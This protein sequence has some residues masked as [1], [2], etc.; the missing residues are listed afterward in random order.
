MV[1]KFPAKTKIGLG[2]DKKN[3]ITVWGLLSETKTKKKT[4]TK[5]KTKAKIETET[6]TKTETETKTNIGSGSHK[7]LKLQ[8]VPAF[9]K[10]AHFAC[11]K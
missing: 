8:R 2:R 5:S 7:R 6:K 10:R 1:G 11:G 3:E 9:T 4:K